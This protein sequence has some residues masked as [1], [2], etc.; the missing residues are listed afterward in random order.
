MRLQLELL[1]PEMMLEEHWVRSTIVVFGG[2]Q[3]VD[4]PRG[5]ERLRAGATAAAAD[6]G[7]PQLARTRSPL[8]AAVGEKP[9]YDAAREFAADRLGNC[10]R[11]TATA[12][13]S[14]VTGGG[15][16]IMEA[17]QSRR[18]RRRRPSRSA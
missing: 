14:I 4:A 5:E 7:N 13:M 11:S 9:Y 17:G 10:A 1:K 2:T 3:I 12:T 15:P 8:R 16:G 6:P 18:P